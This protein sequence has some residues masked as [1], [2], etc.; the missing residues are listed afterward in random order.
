[1]FSLTS[2]YCAPPPLQTGNEK[3]KSSHGR[4]VFA[5]ISN[6]TVSQSVRLK[7]AW[8]FSL[9]N[10]KYTVFES[11]SILQI[12]LVHHTSQCEK[13]QIR[14]YSFLTLIFTCS[15]IARKRQEASLATAFRNSPKLPKYSS[16]DASFRDFWPQYFF[17]PLC[18]V[19]GMRRKVQRG[20]KR[21]KHRT[22]R[23]ICS[24]HKYWSLCRQVSEAAQ[25][26]GRRQLR[27]GCRILA[28]P[29]STSKRLTGAG[30]D[31]TLWKNKNQ[32]QMLQRV[33]NLRRQGRKKVNSYRK[34]G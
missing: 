9:R 26:L 16:I 21:G 3:Q 27:Q 12:E 28:L 7:Q 24:G 25:G 34:M 6:C 10:G 33:R 4:T 5:L 17:H 1:M 8:M 19:H 18:I 30:Q 11:F 29:R 13:L 23:R 2:H 31:R 14:H 22:Q 20:G 32:E 15:E